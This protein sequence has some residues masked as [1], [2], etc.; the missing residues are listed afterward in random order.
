MIV[1]GTK[2]VPNG[3]QMEPK[4][5]RTAT[6]MAPKSIQNDPGTSKWPPLAKF[7]F[8]DRF[9]TRL[10]AAPGSSLAPT[11]VK[12]RLKSK[13]K[14]SSKNDVEKTEIFIT[15]SLEVD[16]KMDTK[17]DQQIRTNRNLRFLDFYKEYNV[18]IV[19]RTIKGT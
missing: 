1:K 15:K 18:K 13:S 8:W 14:I 7:Q 9:W 2:I 19:F 4:W 16:A 12:I 6:R 3:C 17:V 5:C 10:G 11:S